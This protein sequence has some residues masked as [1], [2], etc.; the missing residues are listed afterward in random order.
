MTV[1]LG[2]YLPDIPGEAL[3]NILQQTVEFAPLWVGSG[4]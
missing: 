2:M 3:Q 4:R 1:L